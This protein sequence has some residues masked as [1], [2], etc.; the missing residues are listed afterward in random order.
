MGYKDA[1]ATYESL[2]APPEVHD[3]EQ[4]SLLGSLKRFFVPSGPA[5]STAATSTATTPQ[6][7]QSPTRAPAAYSARKEHVSAPLPSAHQQLSALA[8]AVSPITLAKAPVSAAPDVG[9]VGRDPDAESRGITLPNGQKYTRRLR[10][11]GVTPSVGVTVQNS[12]GGLIQSTTTR[13][14]TGVDG[15]WQPGVSAPA[16]VTGPANV[17]GSPTTSDGFGGLTFAN[18]SSIP[19]FP[20]RGDLGEDSKSVW[21]V[22]TST[23]A[24]P[25]VVQ[26][27]RRL[28]GEG[29]SQEYWMKDESSKACHDCET[30]F[31]VF[32]RKHHCRI[33]GQIFCARCA[34]HLIPSARFGQQGHIR[35]CNLCFSKADHHARQHPHHTSPDDS[36]PYPHA[37][38]NPYHAPPTRSPYAQRPPSVSSNFQNRASRPSSLYQSVSFPTWE[39]GAIDSIPQEDEDAGPSRPESPAADETKAQDEEDDDDESPRGRKSPISSMRKQ[40]EERE[41]S[42]SRDSER[43]IPDM[44]YSPSLSTATAPFRRELAEDDDG[45]SARKRNSSN[46]SEDEA[47]ADAE[48]LDEARSG[49]GIPIQV[50]GLGLDLTGTSGAVQGKLDR[51]GAPMTLEQALDTGLNSSAVNQRRDSFTRYSRP[52]TPKPLTSSTSSS[53]PRPQSSS[54]PS[55]NRSISRLSLSLPDG[56]RPHFPY[57]TLDGPA[58][59]LE[60]TPEKV[61]DGPGD[62]PLCPSS[63]E[64]IRKMIRQALL[65]EGITNVKAWAPVLERLLVQVSNGP[66]PNIFAGDVMDVRRYVRIKKLPGG[67]PKD[68]EFIDGVL[69]TK[70]LL[71]KKM[72]REIESPRILVLTIPLEYEADHHYLQVQSV[73]AQEAENLQIHAKRILSLAPHIV[74]V[75]GNIAQMVTDQLV[76]RGIAAARFIKPEAIAAVARATKAE[77]IQSLD[78]LHAT[79]EL[80]KCKKFRVQT[81]VHPLIP[82]GR[83]SF[84]RFEGCKRELG[85]TILLRGESMETL[86]KLKKIV[87]ML[88]LVVYNAKLEGYL[89]HDERLDLI[90]SPIDAFSAATLSTLSTTTSATVPLSEISAQESPAAKAQPDESKTRLIVQSLEPYRSTALSSSPLVRYPPPYPLVRMADEDR[91]LRELRD[92][93]D[94]DETRK[95]IEEEAA[96]RAQSISAGSSSTSLSSIHQPSI[97]SVLI[98]AAALAQ[99]VSSQKVLQRPEE[100]AKMHE[101]AEAEERYIE[102]LESW[103]EYCDKKQDSLDPVDHQRLYV[104]ESLLYG[105]PHDPKRV[106]RPPSIV[107]VTFYSKEDLTIGQYVVNIV[108][109][110]GLECSSPSC[111]EPLSE[112]SRVFVH[113]DCRTQISIEPWQLTGP[114]ELTLR[115]GI[116]MQTICARCDCRSRLARMSEQTSRLSFHKYLELSFYPSERLV[117]GDQN[118]PH[119]AHLDHTR[120]WYYRGVRIAVTMHRIDLR[121]VVPPPRVV[122][123]KPDTQLLLRNSEYEVVQQRTK[124]FFDSVQARINAFRLDCVQ[125][126]RL[127]ECK[128]ALADF[129][130][131]CEADRRM[132]LRLLVAAYEQSQETNGTEMT[133]VRRALQEKVVQFEA[134]WTLFEKRVI[135][136]EQDSKRSSKR[137]SPDSAMS[138]SPSRRSVSGS[139]PPPIEVE[140]ESAVPNSGLDRSA[141]LPVAQ[142]LESSSNAAAD[143]RPSES[144]IDS[145]S[146]AGDAIDLAA[147]P[148]F[149]LDPPV[150]SLD[151]NGMP[152]EGPTP[153]VTDRVGA[154]NPDLSASTSTVRPASPY[155]TVASDQSD[156]ESDST[157]CADARYPSIG[158]SSSPFI[159]NPARDDGGG[160]SP[161]ESEAEERQDSVR[162]RK[163]GH[164]VSDI[165]QS[166]ETGS[167][168]RSEKSYDSPTRPLLRRGHTDK[169]KPTKIRQPGTLA[170]SDGE[171]S[172]AR[173]VGVLHLLDSPAAAKPT[174]IP[175]RV[176]AKRPGSSLEHLFPHPDTTISPP[177]SRASS[178]PSSRA[179]ARASDKAALHTRDPALSRPTSPVLS[180]GAGPRS[181]E[182]SRSRPT[183]PIA[184]RPSRPPLKSTGS[185]R[186]TIKGKAADRE[187]AARV[188]ES[189]DANRVVKPKARA[190]GLSR[191]T[192]STTNKMVGRRVVSSGVGRVKQMS[193]QWEGYAA[194]QAQRKRARPV[195]AT[196]PTVQIF[197]NVRDAAKEDSDEEA[198]HSHNES[199]AADDE[200]DNEQ[201]SAEKEEASDGEEQRGRS[202][203]CASPLASNTVE[204][205]LSC[206]TPNVSMADA[207]VRSHQQTSGEV[208]V[209]DALPQELDLLNLR[210]DSAMYDLGHFASD[211]DFPSLPSSPMLNS[212]SH[213][214]PRL[215]EGESSGTDKSSY[216]RGLLNG[217][218]LFRNGEFSQLQYPLLPTEHLFADNPILL[219]D[220]E[221]SSIIAFALSSKI[222]YQSVEATKLVPSTSSQSS[223]TALNALDEPGSASSI[224]STI[225]DVLRR[226]D[227]ASL[228]I[229]TEDASLSASC[230]IFFA[231]HFEALRRQCGCERQFIESL[232]R[233]YKWDSSG[234]KSKADFMKT[235][236]D[237]FIVKQLSSWEVDVLSSFLPA[238]FT[239]MADCLFKGQPTVLAKIFGIYRISFGKKYKNLD[240]LVMENLFYG[241]QL[242]QIFDLKGST[243]NRRADSNNPVLLDENLMEI[244]LKTPIYVRE[245]S[246]SFIRQAIHNDSQF[247]SDLNVMDYSLVIGVDSAKHE[248]VVGIVDFIRTYTWNKRIESW[249]KETTFIGGASKAGGPT[250]IT[251][252]QYKMRFREAID[253]Y[254]QLS[255]SPWLSTEMLKSLL[256]STGNGVQPPHQADPPPP[257]TATAA[258]TVTVV[259]VP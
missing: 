167:I 37:Y 65:R 58:K 114:E 208:A 13:S 189:S 109:E 257:S 64:H 40:L 218:F 172:Y 43:D 146:T 178:R 62:I 57:L 168:G 225:E 53:G 14:L 209:A 33:C 220:D 163:T 116:G 200:F 78:L 122:K 72:A 27:F 240:F 205:V 91:H 56:N 121:D 39:H 12:G 87:H 48:E 18:L 151:G 155:R 61:P 76:E 230:K 69:L 236:D 7:E 148:S 67:R 113:G 179:S 223:D 6:R 203:P 219:R 23:H 188:S 9:S 45:T 24:S 127:E 259:E 34:A 199:D 226:P 233:C 217:L 244:S 108:R 187:H 170:L 182:Q 238:Y 134:E 125:V 201:E 63:L 235:L 198:H 161:G 214:M 111:H 258:P 68:S 75:E 211:S 234:G 197:T 115:G 124:A 83:K 118:C 212:H 3:P 253:G 139:L 73:Y 186:S 145:C 19:G 256:P 228:R 71:H 41:A 103:K 174:R 237:R 112:H 89:F 195:I 169:P 21:S 35:V 204:Q 20:L 77:V 252:R 60:G 157:I 207:L 241:R 194:R 152:I 17:N 95:I 84:L 107:T 2:P 80:G 36:P 183:S 30:V 97:S 22:S 232:S 46:G 176:G 196:Q 120:Y 158:R 74:L 49:L 28:Q 206:S 215:S 29:L 135:L 229:A 164:F 16:V 1:R 137:Y 32:R 171:N 153:S 147:V 126:Q 166:F 180:R 213:T 129:S 94:A 92:N 70:N 104:L 10:L 159:R 249:V 177:P 42:R 245:E 105:P 4:E 242:T 55:F 154:I 175:A 144:S 5:P 227:E 81:F 239:Y 8:A 184:T 88:A 190:L 255:P 106:C 248:L 246:Q 25:T 26:I 224:K 143:Q 117:C 150:L 221:P 250:I 131:R 15:S 100:V 119:D 44:A 132:I 181:P 156:I 128:A 90:A 193:K 47:R 138:F 110:F 136:S 66:A 142:T 59:G 93:R 202:P 140:E 243:R 102:R 210:P 231:E 251:P 165:I 38:T 82:G 192:A 160:I 79:P 133:G 149:A 85:C 101:V 185:S 173:N 130:G 96:S 162:R 54:T 222:Y 254:L 98:D 123:V 52:P 191:P 99:G 51:D 216:F 31:T 141:L 11:S 247:L 86:A 50:D